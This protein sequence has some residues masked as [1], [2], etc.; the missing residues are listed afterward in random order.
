MSVYVAEFLGTLI[1]IL[2]G[3]GVVASVI[4]K[5]GKAENAGW[6]PIVMAWGL[7][8]TFAIYAVGNISGAHINPAVTLGLAFVGDFE[9]GKVPGYVIAQ[10]FGAFIGATLVWIFYIP[11][12]SVTKD[13][14]TKLGVFSTIPAMR[15]PIH[16]FFSEMLATALL[17][18][19]LKF[20]GV[21]QFT[22]GLN[23]LVVGALIVLIGLGLGSTTGFAIN[24]A[25]D[26]GPRMA[27][28]LWPIHDKGGSDW[29]YAPIP[30][31]GPVL[32][33]FLGVSLYNVLFLGALEIKYFIVFILACIVTFWAI[34]KRPK[35]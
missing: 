19:A 9:W 33:S 27:H 21:H 35:H 10:V 2:T 29:S 1:L 13:K 7:A 25:R 5:G 17:L 8:V 6:Y 11:H 16:N 18:F 30:I 15:S 34:I 28:F 32:G 20:I 4:L 3:G 22:Q 26:F 23:P 12:W 31:I 14:M 24:P